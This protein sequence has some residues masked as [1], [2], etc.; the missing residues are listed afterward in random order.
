MF[1]K[2]SIKGSRISVTHVFKNTTCTKL[3]LTGFSDGVCGI[4]NGTAGARTDEHNVA[5]V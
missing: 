1:Q 5:G 4:C 3:E 2:K